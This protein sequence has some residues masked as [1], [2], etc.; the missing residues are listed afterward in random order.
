M[1]MTVLP[2]YAYTQSNHEK[3]SN[4]P[5]SQGQEGQGRNEEPPETEGYCEEDTRTEDNARS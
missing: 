2:K 1:S 3:I 4:P 5:K